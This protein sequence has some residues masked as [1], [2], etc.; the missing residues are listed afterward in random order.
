MNKIVEIS[1]RGKGL[2]DITDVISDS[3]RS[4][5]VTD[6]LATL[7]IQH[8]SASLTIQENADPAVLRDLERWM[9][10]AVPESDAYEHKEEG[11]DD[12]PAHIKSALTATHLSIPIIEGRLA[13]GVWQGIFLWEHRRARTSRNVVVHVE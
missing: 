4:T 12:M 2:H 8:T 1:I 9:E 5:G 10:A 13:L 7:F 6:G 3:V 11:S